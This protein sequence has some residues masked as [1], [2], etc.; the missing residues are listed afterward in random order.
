MDYF[1]IHIKKQK[2]QINTVE[3]YQKQKDQYSIE[4]GRLSV[5]T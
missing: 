1:I 5:Y 2:L 3:G 4:A